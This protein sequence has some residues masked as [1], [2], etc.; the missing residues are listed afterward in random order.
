MAQT[1]PL[2]ECD[3]CPLSRK[4]SNSREVTQKCILQALRM[5]GESKLVYAGY[6]VGGLAWDA[7]LL[8][9]IIQQPY[10][11]I[12]IILIDH[13][14]QALM[15][16]VDNMYR[17]S[18]TACDQLIYR[19]IHIHLAKRCKYLLKYLKKQ[20]YRHNHISIHWMPNAYTYY[21]FIQR[22]PTLRADLC[23]WIDPE[24]PIHPSQPYYDADAV[25]LPYCYHARSRA[26]ILTLDNDHT[27]LLLADVNEQR[28]TQRHIWHINSNNTSHICYLGPYIVYP[29]DIIPYAIYI[30]TRIYDPKQDHLFREAILA[31]HE[32]VTHSSLQTRCLPFFI[33]AQLED[34]ITCS[35]PG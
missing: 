23:T 28:I 3:S 6:A 4:E 7:R 19:G 12:A 13:T 5:H 17:I 1:H 10:R 32:L 31:L 24:V 25:Y 14:F 22:N 27:P 15:P 34:V 30:H 8:K 2:Y 20:R 26:Y 21:R 35:A 33:H 29:Y 11:Y 16:A 9:N 18:Q